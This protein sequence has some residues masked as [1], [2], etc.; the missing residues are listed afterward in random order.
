[1]VTDGALKSDYANVIFVNPGI[2]LDETQL[3]SLTTVAVCRT[4]GLWQFIS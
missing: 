2:Q 3:D 4:H 1:V